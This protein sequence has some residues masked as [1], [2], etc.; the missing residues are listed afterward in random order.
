M[1]FKLLSL[2]LRYPGDEILA[3][4]EDI[5]R[6]IG[7]LPPSSAR[8]F[9]LRFVDFWID[10]PPQRLR[11][12]YVDTF[13]FNK[14]GN[15]YLSYYRYGDARIRGQVLAETR[16]AYLQAGF[17]PADTELP[18]YLPLMLEFAWAVPEEGEK[19]LACHRGD[20]E[21]IRKSLND[22]GSPYALLLDALITVLPELDEGDVDE[23][24]KIVM[25]GPPQETVGLEPYGSEEPAD[26]PS[27]NVAFL[28]RKR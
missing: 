4:R 12:R 18:D 23:L 5:A 7:E 14:R 8:E 19:L 11:I 27:P 10:E 13:D 9:M 2:L 26:A 22:D 24:R 21:L 28:G 6:A 17:E 1:I 3:A 16:E 25:H 20:V 15:L